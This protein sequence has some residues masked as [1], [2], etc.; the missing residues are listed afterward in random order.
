MSVDLPIAELAGRKAGFAAG[1]AGALA[2]LAGVGLL[3]VSG[4][5]L[6]GAALAG[7]GGVAAV[8]AFNYLLPSAG[9]RALA[10]TRTLARY[11]E[12]LLGHRDA[13]HSLADLRPR[14][15]ARLAAA[16][17]AQ[18]AQ[19][20]SGTIAANLGSDVEALEDL[21]IRRVSLTS[22]FAGA[23]GGL[24]AAMLAG[25]LP[26]MMLGSG[27]AIS[28]LA[29]RTLAPRWLAAPWSDH[30]KALERLKALYAEYASASVE[31]V[32]YD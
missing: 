6:T 15:F 10:I 4:W 19:R 13:L 25:P 21:A 2:A 28:V 7:A 3:A 12:R 23:L 20:A 5:F 26:A 30:G 32:I 1:L 29:T 11:L 8:Q 24:F 9:I 16:D 14:L 31:L 17:I 27:L 22:A 18:M